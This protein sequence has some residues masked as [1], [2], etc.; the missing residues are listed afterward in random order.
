MLGTGCR[1]TTDQPKTGKHCVRI[2]RDANA[3]APGFGNLM[4]SFDA[5]AYR[6]K[7]VR[8]RAAVRAEVAG[9]RNQAQLWLRVD[10][11]GDQPGFFDNMVD[12]PIT[13]KE[14]R[15]YEIVGEIAPD[16]QTINLGLMLLGNGRAWLD[17][18]S[19]EVIGKAGEGNAPAR[20]LAGRALDNLVAFAKLLGYVR[21]FHPSDAAAKTNW[22]RFAIEGVG[23]V[24][25]AKSPAELA[26]ALQKLF[27]PIAPTVARVSHGPAAGRPAQGGAGGQRRRLVPLRRGYG[28]SAIDLQQR[29]RQQQESSPTA[30]RFQAPGGEAP[31]SAEAI[32][33]RPGRR[34]FVPGSA[35]SLCG[36]EGHAA[37]DD[38]A[39]QGPRLVQTG[40]LYSQRQRSQH[41]A[42]RDGPRL[43][44]L[45]TLLPL[46]RRGEDRLARRC[47][48]R[49]ARR[50]PIRM[51]TP[52]T[53]R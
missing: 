43:E 37:A 3:P 39:G 8:L 44:R 16:A 20:P 32:R 42:G 48:A 25:D 17:A 47:G 51:S 26:Q 9:F 29:A 40:G 46:F 6:G 30:G 1:L 4:Q 21:Y 19:F 23:V 34:R 18:V 49:S 7:R 33:C 45:S 24:E 28:Q 11:Q 36:C 52:S 53:L 22:E 38:R 41:P 10:R 13:Q 14:W 15:D 2:S 31:R 27:Q 5:A 12:R 50:R 35:G